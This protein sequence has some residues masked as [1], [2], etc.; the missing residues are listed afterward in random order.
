M[1]PFTLNIICRLSLL[2]ATLT[3]CLL[4]SRLHVAPSDTKDWKDGVS[5]SEAKALYHT[6]R[7]YDASLSDFVESEIRLT[8]KPPSEAQT[9]HHAIRH[10]RND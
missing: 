10:F 6:F 4:L 1:P 9:R 7:Q 3:P 8:G 2:L 5:R